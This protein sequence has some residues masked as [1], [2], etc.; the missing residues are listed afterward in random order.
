M[1][2]MVQIQLPDGS[3][4]EVPRGTSIAE[5][6]RTQ[7]GPGLAKA[8]LFGKLDDEALDLARPLERSGKLT[9][10][11]SKSPEGLELLRH[12]AAHVTASVVQR[13]FPG[14]QVT[15]GPAIEDG[16]YY[17]FYRETAFT[18]EDLEKIEAAANEEIKRDLPFV[19]EEVSK[20]EALALFER[21]GETFKLEIVNDI[22]ARG[23]KTLTLYRHGD[24]VDFCL[25]PHAP[26]TGRIGVIKLLNVSG[27][28]WRGDASKAQLQRIYGTAFPDKKQLEQYLYRL[29]EAKKRDHRKLGR[30]LGLFTFLPVSPGAPFWLPKGATLYRTLSDAMR[31]LLDESGYVEIK[32]PLLYSKQ[33]WLQSGHWGKYRENMF[34]I[35]DKEQIE[36]FDKLSD[37]ELEKKLVEVGALDSSLKPMNCPSHHLVYALERRS[38]REL[39]LRF[40]T[41]DVL[42]RNEESGAL[43]GL[44]RVRQFTQDDG[45]TYLTEDQ[46]TDEVAALFKL[47]DRVYSGLGLSYEA[48]FST[49]P[50][51][52]LED[53]DDPAMWDKAETMLEAAL[54]QV[55]VPYALKPK[56]GAFYGP[57]IDFDVTDALGRKWQC[58]TIQLDYAA[59]KR[60]NLRYIG[61]DN[62]DDHRPVVIHR[63][64]YGSIERFIAIL[65]EHFAGAFPTWLSPVQA[66][67][68]PLSDKQMEYA[69]TV[70]RTLRKRGL[71]VEIDTDTGDTMGA[72]IRQSEL[73]K[74]PY[75]IVV[76]AKEVEAHAVAPRG[77]GGRDLKQMPLE[78]F[79]EQL[80]TEAKVPWLD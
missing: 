60:F 7:I 30:E 76:G 62:R 46:I 45:H 64:I 38:Y 41:Q 51:N 69:E 70:A 12:D 44:T 11:T 54:K 59:P 2:E 23:A 31:R 58:A 33:L 39:P 34:L 6:V 16:F 57:K 29:E 61:S 78:T 71:R 49:R 37:E 75:A 10:F 14:T 79:V 52:R 55:G 73:A 32:T 8:A 65:I 67:V 43:S 63:A 25:G 9:L 35:L 27:A 24:W 77:R 26:S 18:P 20:E 74:V 66:R 56:D 68:L 42:H 72:R 3:S 40:S 4:K 80:T 36:A 22:F 5:F 53:P 50:D 21:L 15:I 1:S 47:I 13:L 19:R 28:Y 17:D 48:K